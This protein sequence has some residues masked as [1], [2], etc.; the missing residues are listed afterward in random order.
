M[1]TL[2]VQ[3][4]DDESFSWVLSL[5]LL[6]HIVQFMVQLQ[7]KVKDKHTNTNTRPYMLYYLTMKL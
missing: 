6:H 5:Q 3:T 2:P 1:S 4:F 7:D